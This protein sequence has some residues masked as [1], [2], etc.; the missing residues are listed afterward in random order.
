MPTKLRSQSGSGI[1]QYEEV[2]TS[3]YT[4][5][6]FLIHFAGKKGETKID[7]IKHYLKLSKII[8]AY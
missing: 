8:N 2:D 1:G 7:L 3:R 6:D 4:D 5:G